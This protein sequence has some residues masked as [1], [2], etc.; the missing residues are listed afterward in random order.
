MVARATTIHED[1]SRKRQF[2]ATRLSPSAT[3]S[4]DRRSTPLT[5]TT[6]VTATRFPPSAH[7]A[8]LHSVRHSSPALKLFSEAK[9]SQQTP[10]SHSAR[11]LEV[12]LS[13][14]LEPRKRGA[15]P[16]DARLKTRNQWFRGER[17]DRRATESKCSRASLCRCLACHARDFT[18]ATRRTEIGIKGKQER[19]HGF[20]VKQIGNALPPSRVCEGARDVGG[21]S[22][23]GHLLQHLTTF[24]VSEEE[25]TT[26]NQSRACQRQS[27]LQLIGSRF[28]ERHASHLILPHHDPMA[29]HGS[30]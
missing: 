26:A 29:G 4:R 9:A 5:L 15:C 7:D 12:G 2:P 17:I 16:R 19:T 3:A 18:S 13:R 28:A 27:F 24:R 14:Q 25:T 6:Q 30:W 23:S 1:E 8:R 20:P 10:P 11:D 21:A 22:S